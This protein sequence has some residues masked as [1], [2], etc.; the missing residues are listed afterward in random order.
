MKNFIPVY[1]PYLGEEEKLNVNDCLDSSWISSKGKYIDAFEKRTKDYIGANYVSTVSNGTVALH[2]AL[3]AAGISKGDEVIT[4]NF[5]Y[6]A[7]TN[8]ILMVGAKP[9]F[10]E[11]DKD[12]W[13]IDTDLIESKISIKTKAILVTNVYGF[14]C[15]F[16][17]L[18]KICSKHNLLLIEDAAESF[19]AEYEGKKSGSLAD[20][21]TF[22]FFG[23]KTITTGEGGMILT[24]SSEIFSKIEQLKNQGNSKTKRYYHEVLG[25]NY[26]MTN[27][28]AAIGCAQLDKIKLILKLKKD[29]DQF[30][31]S[32]LSDVATFQ[33]AENNSISSFWMSSLLFKNEKLKTRMEQQLEKSNIESRPLFFPIDELPF[34]Q[35]SDTCHVAKR[36]H[37]KGLILPSFPDL[38]TEQLE[39]IVKIIRENV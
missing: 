1:Q 35:K 19:G 34:Y 14:P 29:V 30:Y 10:V 27:I 24:K 17:R 37:S 20:I 4:P 12:T 5:T 9:V 26:R 36:L 2:T 3:L 13:N 39:Y 11:I 7:S 21:S 23:N 33:K 38:T 8:S 32:K 31:R 18:H 28:Q 16:Q 22:S 15:N 6:V 25:Y